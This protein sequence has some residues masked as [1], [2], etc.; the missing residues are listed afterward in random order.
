MGGGSTGVG[1][2]VAGALGLVALILVVLITV[3]EINIR[4]GQD[5]TLM[6]RLIDFPSNVILAL[7]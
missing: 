7:W 4:G 2:G 6:R 5:V 3:I 1:T